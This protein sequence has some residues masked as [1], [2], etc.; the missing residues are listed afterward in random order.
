MTEE[1]QAGHK[2]EKQEEN[3][4]N[5]NRT[6]GKAPAKC[7]MEGMNFYRLFWIFF[8]GCF[9]GVVL[10]TVW[11]I[12]TRGH[13]ESRTGLVYGPFNLVYGFGA[14]LMTL[15]LQWAQ[16]KRDSWIFLGGVLLGSIFEYACSWVQEGLFGTVSWQYDKMPLNLHG[17]INLL[18]SMFWGILAVVWV[19][20]LYPLM[21]RWM[22][23][24]PSKVAKPLT[25]AL[26][27]FMIINTVMSGLAIGRMAERHEEI[28]ASGKVEEWLDSHYDDE[29]LGRIYPNMVFVA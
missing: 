14:V 16:K 20:E 7:F 15:G 13:Y 6:L 9:L 10:E 11:C 21:C 24:I 28:P 1:K 22:G 26:T 2:K 23:K 5:L 27:V 4:M 8:Y 3:K 18:Y 12:L 19:K 25:W 17:R 29:R